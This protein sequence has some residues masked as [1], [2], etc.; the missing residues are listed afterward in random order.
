[1]GA[2]ISSRVRAAAL[3]SAT[4]L[5]S[6]IPAQVSAQQTPPRWTIGFAQDTLSNDWRRAQTEGLARA[7]AS[8]PEIR[9]RHTDAGGNTA[10]QVQDIERLV[11]E[12]VDLLITSPR[13]AELMAPVIDRVRAR[14]IPVVLLSRRTASDSHNVFIRAENRA[15]ARQAAAHLAQRLGG[16]GRILMLQHI[17]TTTP[18]IERTEGFMEELAKHPGM[19]VVAVRRADSL[20]D[21]A[22]LAVDEVLAAGIEFDAIY[23][24]SDSMAAGARAALQRRGIDPASIPTVGIDYIAEAREAIRA[25]KQDASFLYPTF[26]KEGAEAALRLLRG[27]P[28]AHEIVVETEKITRDNVELVEPIF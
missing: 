7:F 12:G 16:K 1:M 18:A 15:I 20:R 27:E 26:A 10:R 9:F 28:V 25:G 24:Q 5:I 6:L 13:D 17:P 23:A 19:S 14:G 4:F 21:K 22:I 8:H 3:A 11:D 2:W